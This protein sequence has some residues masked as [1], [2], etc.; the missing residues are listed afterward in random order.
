MGDDRLSSMNVERS[1][2]MLHSQ[3]SLQNEGELVELGS[4]PRFEPSLGAA[5]VGDTGSG[6]F[7]IHSSDIFVDDFWFIS[8]GLNARGL[9]DESRHGLDFG[10]RKFESTEFLDYNRFEGETE[11]GAR[12]Q[13]SEDAPQEILALVVTTDP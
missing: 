1:A 8:G 13:G 3:S 6:R 11:S 2:L 5:H 10:V 7:G 12:G 4:L 9:R